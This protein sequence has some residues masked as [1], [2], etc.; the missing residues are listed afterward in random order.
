MV[1][2][3]TV[4]PEERT[5]SI[6]H[7][8]CEGSVPVLNPADEA[9]GVSSKQLHRKVLGILMSNCREMKRIFPNIFAFDRAD[10]TFEGRSYLITYPEG[11]IMIDS[12]DFNDNLVERITEEGGIRWIFITHSDDVGDAKDFRAK[13]R[14]QICIH[15]KDS[16]SVK[17]ADMKFKG[18]EELAAHAQLIHTPGHTPGSSM[19]LAKLD[20]HYLFTGDTILTTAGG[21]LMANTRMYTKSPSDLMESVRKL[22]QFKVDVILPSHGA[23]PFVVDATGAFKIMLEKMSGE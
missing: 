3:R 19:L 14:S 8:T 7:P 10:S 1:G 17:D 21:G 4:V 11:N 12:P 22:S 16:W 5:L 20:Q 9:A 15:N 2:F 18:G 13:F 6:G 23:R